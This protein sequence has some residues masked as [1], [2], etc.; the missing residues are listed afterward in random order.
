LRATKRIGGFAIPIWLIVLLLLA[1]VVVGAVFLTLQ[2]NITVSEPLSVTMTPSDS[3]PLYPG[4]IQKVT[5]NIANTAGSDVAYT[6]AVSHTITTTGSLTVPDV[7]VSYTNTGNTATVISGGNAIIEA[8]VVVASTALDGT[9]T[10]TFSLD[11][12]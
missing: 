3:I 4:E 9:A 10:V 1:P 7:V 12:A 6:V 5:F 2:L 11:R 8:D